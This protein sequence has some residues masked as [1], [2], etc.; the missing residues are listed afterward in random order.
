MRR[1]PL[2]P[3]ARHAVSLP[4]LL[5]VTLLLSGCSP[6]PD[7]ASS[8]TMPLTD[9]ATLERPGSPNT[10]LIAPPG[11]VDALTPDIAAP[12]LPVPAARLAAAWTETVAAQPRSEVVTV[13]NDGLQ[14]E[15]QQRSALFRFVDDVSFRAVP[16]DDTH[17][18]F[19][20]YSRSRVGYWDIG[21]NRKRLTAWTDALQ[22][23]LRGSAPR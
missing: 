16:I 15:A 3:A 23:R 14:V 12:A 2:A 4:A 5:L 9:F 17:S 10:W 6:P 7:R 20:A 1:D 18:T 11:A 21:V 13:S 8:E 22:A 19:I